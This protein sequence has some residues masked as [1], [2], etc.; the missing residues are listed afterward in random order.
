MSQTFYIEADEE[1]ISVIGRLRKSGAEENIFVFPKRALVLQSI[2]NLRLFQ[3]EAEKLG[4]KIII[5]TQDEIGRNLAGK[6]GIET[7]QY[8][9]DF[10]QKSDRVEIPAY[11]AAEGGERIVPMETRDR[12]MPRAENIGS[13]SFHT[14]PEA[15]VSRPE[16]LPK[17]EIVPPVSAPQ[18]LRVRDA[19]PP[20]QTSLNSMR[21][22]EETER[23][24]DVRMSGNGQVPPVPS[25]PM[26]PPVKLPER[27]SQPV[28]SDR[29]ERLKNFFG[30]GQGQGPVSNTLSVAAPAP[31]KI[32]AEGA[33]IPP[34]VHHKA[35]SIIFI[36]GGISILSLIGVGVFLFL[37]KAEVFVT[38][39]KMTESA[40]LVFEG[41]PDGKDVTGNTEKLPVRLVEGD[42][43]IA[44]SATATGKSGA[45]NQKS[46][47][48]VIIYN[49]Y[50]GDPQPLVATTR[51]ETNGKVF[52]LVEGVT[53]PG[54][55]TTGG[56]Q[57]PGAVEASVV[58]DQSGSEYNVTPSTFTIPGF[59]G[60]PKYDKF[61]AKSVK[62]F[63][64]GGAGGS[65]TL[66]I[67][68]TDLE[69]AEMDGKKQA[70][71]A[72][73]KDMGAKLASGERV[74]EDEMEMVPLNEGALPQVGTVGSGFEYRQR[75][76]VRAFVYSEQAV[77]EAI[78]KR[79]PK[80]IQGV[81]FAPKDVDLRY[82]EASLDF[83]AKTLRLRAHADIILE[84]VVESDR[85]R[86]ALLG[87][88]EDGIREALG[89]FPEI[90]KIEV[91]FHPDF[92]TSTIP[93]AAGRVT[94]I[95]EPG[96]E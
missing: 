78:A 94:V 79:Y 8:T 22:A 53:V 55:T 9:E 95:V 87:Q 3:R 58:A 61:Y 6:A 92:F 37:P 20:K 14:A 54:M 64:G 45:A 88:S 60:S 83:T 77:R 93:K 71:D 13:A 21:Y 17:S 10:S 36:L 75:Y 12:D 26:R 18:P 25:S 86:E 47:G 41:G 52:R 30:N 44:L 62:A 27:P 46:R 42:Q 57:E 23:K 51:L 50:S 1:I 32:P 69:R 85:V 38:P 35:K 90:K 82:G 49:E 29:G 7:E 15:T 81:T 40:D 16:S 19:S 72:F 65:D 48:T 24:Q 89:A 66:V 80:D 33:S 96:E 4:K 91:S 34:H 70:K 11:H 31:K 67:S 39:H 84:S 2:V 56:K 74:F 5:V 73:L 63:T 68:K 43:E 76:H 28:L 59:K